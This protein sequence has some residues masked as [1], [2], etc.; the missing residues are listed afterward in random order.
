MGAVPSNPM[1]LGCIRSLAHTLELAS[2]WLHIFIA[3]HPHAYLLPCTSVR[4]AQR[5]ATPLLEIFCARRSRF[6]AELERLTWLSLT[7]RAIF[8]SHLV[9]GVL[10]N[11]AWKHHQMCLASS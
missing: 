7:S 4:R 3:M 9:F 5:S 6:T 2:L 1:A 8:C 11:L 10:L